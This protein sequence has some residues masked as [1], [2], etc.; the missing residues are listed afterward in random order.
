VLI[1]EGAP[2]FYRRWRADSGTSPTAIGQCIASGW[3]IKPA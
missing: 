3:V 2:Q 1:G